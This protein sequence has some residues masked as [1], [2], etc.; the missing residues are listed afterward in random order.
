M[1]FLHIFEYTIIP[2][3]CMIAIGYILDKQ[4]HLDQG[5][6]NKLNFYFIMPCFIFSCI[7]T[8]EFTLTNGIIF[9]AG[10]FI[11]IGHRFLADG[12]TAIMGYDKKYQAT[13][14]N[15]TMFNNCGNLGVAIITLIFSNPPYVVNGQT[16]YIAEATMTQI[17]LLILINL[18]LN[19]VGIYQAGLGMMTKRDALRMV[20]HMPTIYCVPTAVL[21]RY[22]DISLTDTFIWPAIYRP[23]QALFPIAMVSLGMQLARAHIQLQ[24]IH[25]WIAIAA[26]LLGGPA[27][28]YLVI[29]GVG[30]IHGPLPALV[31]QVIFIY[32]SVPCAV[33]AVLFAAEFKSNPEIAAQIVVGSTILSILSLPCVIT[34][35]NLLFPLVR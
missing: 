11:M 18:T 10:V 21:L 16:P 5:T 6:L 22:F 24:N 30:W 34:L 32:A 33:N 4:F 25:A 29:L 1:I 26:R 14:R 13:L 28:A 2:I 23:G 8:T 27:V 9:L 20:L 31:E 35:A 17:T 15:T 3:F 19:T 7:M 12:I